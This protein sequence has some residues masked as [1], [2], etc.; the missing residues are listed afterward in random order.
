MKKRHTKLIV[1]AILLAVCLSA[2][3]AACKHMP[4][5][6]SKLKPDESKIVMSASVTEDKINIAVSYKEKVDAD[7]Q[8]D[9]DLVAVK[10]YQYL[11]GDEFHGLS[12]DVLSVEKA[13]GGGQARNVQNG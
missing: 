10:A 1:V 9:C 13:L 12:A 3:L 2:V 8:S 11:Q 6:D 5:D 4:T 7:K